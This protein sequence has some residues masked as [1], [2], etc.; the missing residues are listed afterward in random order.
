[1]VI[2]EVRSENAVVKWVDE[3]V[4]CLEDGKQ[5]NVVVGNQDNLLHAKHMCKYF[6]YAVHTDVTE[7]YAVKV[8]RDVG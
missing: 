3:A 5:K 1:M 4:E 8:R 7:K 6:E 2:A